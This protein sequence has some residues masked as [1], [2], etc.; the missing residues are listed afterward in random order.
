MSLINATR[1]NKLLII[2]FSLY[3]KKSKISEMKET[4]YSIVSKLVFLLV[5]CRCRYI[6]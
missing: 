6:N 2:R 1:Q 4:G 3:N 5:W